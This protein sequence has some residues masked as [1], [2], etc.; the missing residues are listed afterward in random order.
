[1]KEHALAFQEHPVNPSLMYARLLRWLEPCA[2]RLPPSPVTE[3]FPPP[4]PPT[5]DRRLQ[6]VMRDKATGKAPPKKG[7]GKRSGKK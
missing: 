2:E 5:P 4:S 3:A 1:M 7:Q 6:R